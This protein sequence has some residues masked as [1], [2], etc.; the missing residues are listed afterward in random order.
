MHRSHAALSHPLTGP[1]AGR[2][3]LLAVVA[4]LVLVLAACSREPYVDPNEPP[5]SS[6]TGTSSSACRAK[7]DVSGAVTAKVKGEGT[8]EVSTY[9][10]TPQ[11][12]SYS[13][14]EGDSTMQAF[15]AGAEKSY[16]S[17]V[18]TQGEQTFSSVEADARGIVVKDD[19]TR[20]SGFLQMAGP[21]APP[22]RWT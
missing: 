10:S 11:T 1:V 2:S 18:F 3:A 17:L 16:A 19:G 22:S 6:P 12:A 5:T 14:S 20:V 9:V 21:T 4:C 7:F 13:A 8:A 15:S